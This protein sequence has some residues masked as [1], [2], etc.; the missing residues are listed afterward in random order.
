MMVLTATR[1]DRLRLSVR[2]TYPVKFACPIRISPLISSGQNLSR[3]LSMLISFSLCFHHS[4]LSVLSCLPLLDLTLQVLYSSVVIIA[5]TLEGGY[6]LVDGEHCFR[7]LHRFSTIFHHFGAYL[8]QPFY[9]SLCIGL[10]CSRLLYF[11]FPSLQDIIHVAQSFLGG[12]CLQAGPSDYASQVMFE[13][14]LVGL[15]VEDSAA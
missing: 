1:P 5:Q 14:G 13:V 8:A 6:P 4:R 10:V 3:V 11:Q 9:F 12:Y 2:I 15:R 7:A